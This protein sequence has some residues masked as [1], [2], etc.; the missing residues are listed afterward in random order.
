MDYLV[1]LLLYVELRHQRMKI[2]SV[3]WKDTC[4]YTFDLL[5]KS[6]W[7]NLCIDGFFS[8]T[9]TAQPT[10]IKFVRET[11]RALSL[12]L[13]E[14]L[15]LELFRRSPGGQKRTTTVP[16]CGR[17]VY[18][19][20]VISTF[21]QRE[22]RFRPSSEIV[23]LVLFVDEKAK[24][25]SFSKQRCGFI[26]A[27]FGGVT[28]SCVASASWYQNVTK[29]IHIRSTETDRRVFLYPSQ[30]NKKSRGEDITVQPTIWLTGYLWGVCSDRK[31]FFNYSCDVYK[32]FWTVWDQTGQL[33]I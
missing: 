28:V 22:E 24:R 32:K 21:L 11:R 4:K 8:L 26:W 17:N 3:N 1:N 20:W 15:S 18:L 27:S 16:D 19:N 33:W 9:F 31:H 23:K 30:I 6:I 7:F 25:A 13:K 14:T 2:C 5:M 10:E 29:Y 12:S